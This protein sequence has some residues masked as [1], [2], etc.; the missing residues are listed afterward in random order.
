MTPEAERE[1]A[2]VFAEIMQEMHPELDVRAV[3]PTPDDDADETAD[4][5]A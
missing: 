3:D 5:D 1:L 4:G 2:R